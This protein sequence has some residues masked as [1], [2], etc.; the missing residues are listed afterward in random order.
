LNEDE[1]NSP[2]KVVQKPVEE[3]TTI[4]EKKKKKN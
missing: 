1:E 3:W 4:E 2:S